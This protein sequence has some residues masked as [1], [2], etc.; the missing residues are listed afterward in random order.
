MVILIFKFWKKRLSIKNCCCYSYDKNSFVTKFPKKADNL[1]NDLV[2]VYEYRHRN[3]HHEC[4]SN[5]RR[6]YNL[7]NG[8]FLVRD[9]K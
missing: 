3:H 9:K 2:N 5:Y 8:I 7:H 4:Y 6:E 1:L